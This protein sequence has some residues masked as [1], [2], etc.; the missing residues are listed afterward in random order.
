[1]S[2]FDM[3][4][5][6]RSGLR[7]LESNRGSDDVEMLLI[8]R[9]DVVETRRWAGPSFYRLRPE[10]VR[11]TSKTALTGQPFDSEAC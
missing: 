4:S 8:R 1:M 6:D 11:T 5:S 9:R 3:L 10:L 2:N 7:L